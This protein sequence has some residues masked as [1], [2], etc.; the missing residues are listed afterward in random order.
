MVRE[1]GAHA[2]GMAIGVPGNYLCPENWENSVNKLREPRQPDRVPPL[3]PA[4]ALDAAAF[5]EIR[6]F[7]AVGLALRP[8]AVPLKTLKRKR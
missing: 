5:A 4:T 8:W 6:L 1:C 7:L 2:A 3:L